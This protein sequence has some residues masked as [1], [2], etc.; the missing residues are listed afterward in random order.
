MSSNPSALK[1]SFLEMLASERGSAKLS[2]EAYR[3][4]L[5]DFFAFTTSKKLTLETLTHQHVAGYN[6]H[7]TARAMSSATI[8][9]RRSA[10]KQ[11]FGFLVKEQVRADNPL[12]L[13]VASKP[14]R[15]LPHVL[16][17]AE[18]KALSAEASRDTSAEG[19]RLRA[20]LELTYASGMRV[21]ELVTL[22]LQHLERDPKKPSKL[23]PFLMVRGKGNKDRI[24]PLHSGAL[25]ALQDYLE[26]REVFVP[27]GRDSRFLFPS[28]GKAGHLTRQRFHQAL[29]QLCVQAGIN[30]EHCSPH[31]L[32]HSFATHLLEGG[33]DLRVIQELLGHADIST[34]QIYT[35]VAGNRLKETVNKKHP[36]AKKRDS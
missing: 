31:T 17:H 7:L 2:I 3:R 28:S 4:D 6:S 30:P 34:T 5:D 33:A 18:L 20:L 21:S 12:L 14:T 8:A 26:V 1:N 13:V 15:S 35:H 25:D 22:T 36:L 29:K 10:L 27:K 16:Q 11:F 23:Q 19:L 9:R 32:R 24:V